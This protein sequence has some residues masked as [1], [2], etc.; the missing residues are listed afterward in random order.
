[1]GCETGEERL[2]LVKLL[3]LEPESV[4]LRGHRAGQCAVTAA[5]CSERKRGAPHSDVRPGFLH[6]TTMFT[7]VRAS[8]LLFSP[9]DEAPYR[10]V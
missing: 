5:F 9:P 1:M 8:I 3:Q 10:K 6:K 4:S 2:K 7:T